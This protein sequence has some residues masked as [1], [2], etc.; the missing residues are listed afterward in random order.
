LDEPPRPY[1][2]DIK[3]LALALGLAAILLALW[4]FLEIAS[5]LKGRTL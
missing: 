3:A 2:G 1:P 5:H 4:A